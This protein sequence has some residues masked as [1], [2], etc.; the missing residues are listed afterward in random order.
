MRYAAFLKHILFLLFLDDQPPRHGY[1]RGRLHS[2]FDEHILIQS[3]FHPRNPDDRITSLQCL[4]TSQLA[5]RVCFPW[6]VT[7]AEA[8]RAPTMCSRALGSLLATGRER[9]CLSMTPGHCA[10]K[11]DDGDEDEDDGGGGGCWQKQRPV[12]LK[13]CGRGRY[14]AWVF[15]E[16]NSPLT[17]QNHSNVS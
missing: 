13:G 12:T 7:L 15:H 16:W 10:G 17:T 9:L 1:R 8:Q 3:S 6:S 14:R 4:C 2:H 11:D 5:Y